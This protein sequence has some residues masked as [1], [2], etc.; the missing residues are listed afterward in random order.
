MDN[1]EKHNICTYWSDDYLV[2]GHLRTVFYEI[3]WRIATQNNVDSLQE[4]C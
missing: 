2:T 1:V 4:Y 3:C